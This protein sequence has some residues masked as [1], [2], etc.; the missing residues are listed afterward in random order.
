MG[1][2]R[3]AAVCVCRESW[4]RN[5][6]QIPLT[7][8][9]GLGVPLLVRGFSDGGSLWHPAPSPSRSWDFGILFAASHVAKLSLLQYMCMAGAS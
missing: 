3:T 1:R 8:M 2:Q 7:W 6:R 4:G 5:F 9:P